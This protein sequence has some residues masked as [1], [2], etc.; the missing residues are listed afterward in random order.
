M[1]G[2]VTTHAG[3]KEH[4]EYSSNT[5][6]VIREVVEDATELRPKVEQLDHAT[7]RFD[8]RF[9]LY[10]SANARNTTTA[11]FESTPRRSAT[12]CGNTRGSS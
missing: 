12:G 6:P 4:D 1:R 3:S 8:A 7:G 10:L 2:R 11:F 5:E 9:R